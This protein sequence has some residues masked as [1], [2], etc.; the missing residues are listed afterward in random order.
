MWRCDFQWTTVLLQH[1]LKT[2]KSE[3]HTT[4]INVTY[5]APNRLS[6][7]LFCFYWIKIP[8][9]LQ[10][11][12]LEKIRRSPRRKKFKKP[13]EEKM[14]SQSSAPHPFYVYVLLSS[15]A[16]ISHHVILTV[17]L[18][19]CKPLDDRSEWGSL[20]LLFLYFHFAISIY[21]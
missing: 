1:F 12:L 16:V 21:Y 11:K 15:P 5:S 10:L 19:S 6:H 7:F 9:A 20:N 17:I 14:A 3:K 18:V 2:N 8:P 13:T 4:D